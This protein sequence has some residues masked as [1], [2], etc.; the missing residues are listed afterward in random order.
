MKGKVIW[1]EERTFRHSEKEDG[2]A[3]IGECVVHV[4]RFQAPF[5]PGTGVGTYY[6]TRESWT[7]NRDCMYP[8]WTHLEEHLPQV[9]GTEQRV[10]R[11]AIALMDS[12]LAILPD[13]AEHWNYGEQD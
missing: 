8:D 7:P 12:M 13:L 5:E 11:E 3:T 2:S 1:K 6:W 4:F 9:S 10:I